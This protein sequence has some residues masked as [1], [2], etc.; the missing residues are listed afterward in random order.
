MGGIV[1]REAFPGPVPYPN[2]YQTISDEGNDD[3]DDKLVKGTGIT[4][5]DKLERQQELMD[6]I[7]KL[8]LRRQQLPTAAAV[9]D[10]GSFFLDVTRLENLCLVAS[11]LGVGFALYFTGTPVSYYLVEDLDASSTQVSI[12]STL[13]S[14]PW[15]FKIFYGLLSDG[16]PIAGYR[17]K[18]YLLLGWLIY[19][20]GNFVLVFEGTPGIYQTIIWTFIQ[21]CGLL[22]ADVATDTLCV[23]RARLETD[24]SRGTLQ[25]LGYTYRAVGMVIGA[26]GGTILYN[27]DSWGWGLT[28]AQIFFANG[29]F[30]CILVLPL[31]FPLIELASNVPTPDWQTQ[32]TSVWETLQLKAV[33]Q[34]MIFI[35]VY[36]VM[37]VPNSAWYNFL[38]D[39]LDFSNFELG[40]LTISSAVMT[41]LGLVAY[42]KYLFN[43][44]WRYIYIL[45]TALGVFFSIL[46]LL[47][48]YQINVEI[49]IPD[50]VF[51]LGDNTI[52]SFVAALQYMPTCIMYVILCPE[53]SEG[54]TYALLTTI[55][56]LAG[57]R[58]SA[59]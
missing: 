24:E 23:E 55:S 18:P 12:M 32:W 45:T 52:A 46:Q 5:D 8:A 16:V 4:D 49:G 58:R 25:S 42:K 36:N 31:T 37:Q 34:P 44:S 43:A 20:I 33:W 7:D 11:Y 54:T 56:N 53:G 28:I 39:G 1:G 6:H 10:V 40:L 47:L 38:V 48:V 17:R 19:I 27:K 35:Y 59:I 15:S 9:T 22:M 51:A 30:P 26:V 57:V 41:W 13:T 2:L 21:T 14:L 29:F 50:V 3:E